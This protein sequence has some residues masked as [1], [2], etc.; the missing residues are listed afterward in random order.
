MNGPLTV[1]RGAD[2]FGSQMLATLIGYLVLYE[3]NIEFQYSLIPGITL[4]MGV[5]KQNQELSKINSVLSQMMKNLGVVPAN[6]NIQSIEGHKAPYGLCS[7]DT[8]DSEAVE[9]LKR[10]W[11]IEKPADMVDRKTLSIHIRRGNDIASDNP[12]RWQPSEYYNKLIEQ[13]LKCFPDYTIQLLSWGDPEIDESLKAKVVVNMSS[14][15]GEILDHY[16]RMI[17]SDILIVGSSTFSI[18]AGLLNNGV[19]LCDKNIISITAPYPSVWSERY[20]SLIG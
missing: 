15:G 14:L 19:V 3:R 20:K 2:G 13:C 6:N 1:R 7:K 5:G 10:C 18:S 11:P 12:S 4:A 9:K 8:F 16:N 17:H